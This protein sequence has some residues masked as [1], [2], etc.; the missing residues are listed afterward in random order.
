MRMC[1]AFA[2][3]GH[4]VTLSAL[5]GEGTDNEVFEYY[6]AK[7]NI[8][9]IRHEETRQLAVNVLANLRRI[10]G[11]R[12]GGLP[13]VLYGRMMIGPALLRHPPDLV[14][15]RNLNWLLGIDENIGFVAESHRPPRNRVVHA[16]EARLFCRPGFR[17]LVV[18]SDK[19]RDNYLERYP[20]LWGRILVAHD[21]ADDPYRV[22]PIHASNSGPGFNI[23]YV[24]HLYSGRGIELIKAVAIQ[25]PKMIF[26]LVGG[27][28]N[29]M[30]R[31]TAGVWPKNIILHG[32]HPPSRLSAFYSQFDVVLAPYERKV[33]V[34]DESSDTSAYM[35]PLKIFEYMAWAKPI[36]C[37]DLPVLREVLEHEST[38]LLLPPEDVTAW[39]SALRRL[40]A[41]RALR[42]R[43]GKSA[44]EK[45]LDHYTWAKRA[46]AVLTGLD[47]AS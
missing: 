47:P 37:S 38:A 10:P 13:S 34:G 8:T 6:G 11:M 35:S 19:L 21:A 29:D 15:A 44:H 7:H 17:R 28:E 23:G 18:I 33:T 31:L 16:L 45:F 41:D 25:L 4:K 2:G 12:I 26:H 1:Q 36:L 46:S 14:Y 42:L 22:S 39:V 27:N 3:L 40:Q 9:L 20:G 30:T 24:G 32:H 5:L 43:L